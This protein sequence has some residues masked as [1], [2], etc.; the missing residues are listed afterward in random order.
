MSKQKTGGYV[1]SFNI[2]GL[3]P[4]TS[5]YEPEL[6]TCTQSIDELDAEI[7]RLR[8]EVRVLL[9]CFKRLKGALDE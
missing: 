3:M 8:N 6:N 2:Q 4:S 1:G 9:E 7:R 5:T